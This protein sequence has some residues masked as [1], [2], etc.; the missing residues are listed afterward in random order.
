MSTAPF[1]PS[2]GGSRGGPCAFAAPEQ[3]LRDRRFPS[4][5]FLRLDRAEDPARPRVDGSKTC[6]GGDAQERTALVGRAE[7][8]GRRGTR[9]KRGGA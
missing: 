5:L 2:L 1:P 4:A 3:D 6:R 9:R 8:E 7:R